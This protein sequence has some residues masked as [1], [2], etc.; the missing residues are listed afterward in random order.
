MQQTTVRSPAPGVTI[1]TSQDAAGASTIVAPPPPVMRRGMSQ[2]GMLMGMF[3]VTVLFPL[4]VALAIRMLRRGRPVAA[5][6]N[7]LAARLDRMEQAIESS[8]IEIERIG[9][10]QRYLTRVLSGDRSA[11]QVG[12]GR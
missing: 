9:E 8:A 3:M 11:E 4:A 7:D 6:P 1:I 2:G 12:S 5:I 10:G